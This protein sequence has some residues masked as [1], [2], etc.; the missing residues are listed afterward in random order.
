V[1]AT[2]SKTAKPLRLLARRG[3]TPIAGL[4]DA[5]DANGETWTYVYRK[6]DTYTRVGPYSR[7]AGVG[8]SGGRAGEPAF[9]DGPARAGRATT[10]RLRFAC[11]S[12]RAGIR[13]P[14]RRSRDPERV[15]GV[16]RP[17]RRSL[18]QLSGFCSGETSAD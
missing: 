8:G 7:V 16:S 14:V 10:G 17:R 2:I 1:I 3:A 15:T 18:A 5:A 6:E 11:N 9:Y 4:L 12:A 13:H